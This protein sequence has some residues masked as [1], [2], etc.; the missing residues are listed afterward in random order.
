M[1]MISHR[2]LQSHCQLVR[3]EI[4]F[5][6]QVN[7]ILFKAAG[8]LQVRLSSAPGK[9]KAIRAIETGFAPDCMNNK[10]VDR[11]LEK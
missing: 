11:S 1:R 9:E 2:F 6:R 5:E 4:A 7:S 8:R 3:D 10:S